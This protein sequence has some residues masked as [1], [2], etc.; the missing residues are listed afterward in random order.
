M[1]GFNKIKMFNYNARSQPMRQKETLLKKTYTTSQ[2]R[3]L[4]LFIS[5]SFIIWSFVVERIQRLSKRE[6]CVHCIGWPTLVFWLPT[7][8]FVRRSWAQSSACSFAILLA[9]APTSS[10]RWMHMTKWWGTQICGMSRPIRLL[11]RQW[12]KILRKRPRLRRHGR[13]LMRKV[14]AKMYTMQAKTPRW[15][16]KNWSFVINELKQR[17][18][19]LKT[20]LLA[21]KYR[22][23]S[24][25]K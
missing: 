11:M 17:D 16:T 6:Y 25:L 5:Y 8:G 7:L 3:N 13:N 9:P 14:T 10:A 1:M 21:R 23:W 22:M 12:G 24:A 19:W 2:A 18:I 20:L 4:L 15:K